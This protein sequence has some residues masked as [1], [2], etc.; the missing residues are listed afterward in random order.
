[1]QDHVAAAWCLRMCE[2]TSLVEVWCETSDDIT[3]YWDV[4]REVHEVE[5][6]QVKSD[7]LG[8]LWSVA[9][10][11][12]AAANANGDGD[13]A[14]QDGDT[15][16]DDGADDA[17][18]ID[19]KPNKKKKK[20]KKKDA[21]CILETSLQNDRGIEKSRFRIVTCRPI[22]DELKVLTYDHDSEHRA[23]TTDG[24]LNLVA[25]LQEKEKIKELKSLN[26]NGCE[27]WVQRT[28]WDVIHEEK[29]IEGANILKV[30][31][32]AQKH[33]QVLLPDQAR[34]VYERLLTR[35]LRAGQAD[36]ETELDQKVFKRVDFITWFEK[37]IYDAA[38][39]GKGGAGKTLEEKL[40]DAKV[41][42]DIIET[43][44]SLRLNYLS[45]LFTPRYSDP[46]KRAE[47]ETEIDARL[48]RLRQK[49]DSGELEVSGVTFHSMCM[50]AVEQVHEALPT[51]D[52]PPL[53][54]LYGFMYN[55]ADRCT[56]RFV[57]AKS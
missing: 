14:A 23:I 10:L 49:I 7:R 22:M 13:N 43:A 51:K 1:V 24:Y 21:L 38:H 3:L 55:L 50:D 28:R 41:A 5:F 6:V 37:A 42:D 12:A 19:G 11:T 9:L 45:R 47:L 15:D 34:T 40:T 56:H 29:P 2:D 36:W 32:L 33:G 17:A 48:M 4:G 16:D 8:Q 26:G 46:E 53:P 35:V 54:N 57:R 52:R 39:P 31:E 27:Y 30:W 18:P 44:R 25:K 20:A